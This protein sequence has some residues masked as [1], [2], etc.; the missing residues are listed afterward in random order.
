M[1]MPAEIAPSAPQAAEPIDLPPP[2]YPM[3]V[4]MITDNVADYGKPPIR[5]AIN[6]PHPFVPEMIVERMFSD[7]DGVE[8]YS[9]DGRKV[10][11]RDLIQARHVYLVQEGM[12][13]DIFA[14]VLDDAERAA[15]T[16]P[17]PDPDS[18]P[19]APPNGQP[20]A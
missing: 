3:V 2:G 12:P 13:I 19:P 17:P 10:G 5:W 1:T 8:I 11:M 4:L 14:D 15:E 16:P 20:T 18:E 7:T 9:H 6:Q